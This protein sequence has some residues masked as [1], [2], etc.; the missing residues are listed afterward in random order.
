MEVQTINNHIKH[1]DFTIY[2]KLIRGCYV[3]TEYELKQLLDVLVA[4]V[5]CTYGHV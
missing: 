1:T 2:L 3:S 5:I 4:A